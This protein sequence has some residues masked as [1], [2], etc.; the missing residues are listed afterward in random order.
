MQIISQTPPIELRYLQYFVAAAEEMSFRKAA[1]RLHVTAPAMTMQIKKLEGLLG[2]LLFQRSPKKINLTP[3][4]RTLL[5][6]ARNVLQHTRNLLDNVK[7]SAGESQR[8]LRVG[9]ARIFSRS[10]IT[11]AIKAHR[12]RYPAEVVD[13][14][15]T[16]PGSGLVEALE[17]GHIQLGF[18]YDFNLP[19][20]KQV[21]RLLVMDSPVQVVM[22][23]QHPLATREQVPLAALAREDM[24]CLRHSWMDYQ[25]LTALLQVK[26]PVAPSVKKVNDCEIGVLAET[27]GITLLSENQAVRLAGGKLVHRPIKGAGADFRVRLYAVWKKQ[28]E[29]PQLVNFLKLLKDSR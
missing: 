6:D 28:M 2:V 3:E 9:V 12:L 14:V 29:T 7:R 24:L 23:A 16:A 25:D 20:L 13:W 8:T 27:G 1:A 15:E 19:K 22:G 5:R 17:G 21:E 4:G 10:F 11:D 26:P 18:V